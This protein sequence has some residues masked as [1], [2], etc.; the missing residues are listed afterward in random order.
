M[1]PYDLATLT[2]VKSW[3]FGNSQDNNWPTTGDQQAA[4][5][6]T[7]ASRAILSYLGRGTI[8]PHTIT[9][10]RSGVGGS[11]MMLKDY[12]VLYVNTLQIGTQSIPKRPP[13]S[14]SGSTQVVS[15]FPGGPIGWALDPVWDGSP[16]GRS[17]IL[18]VEGFEFERGLS[19]IVVNYRAGY[20][21]Y[22]EAAV[23]PGPTNKVEC[24]NP[25]GRWVSDEGVQFAD[26]TALTAVTKDP[27]A[28]QYVPPA[29]NPASPDMPSWSYTFNAADQGKAVLLAYGF[30]PSD[31]EY[32]CT[33]WV[34]EWWAYKARPG[35]RSRAMPMGAGTATFDLSAM[36][37]D[38]KL[39]LQ[40]FKR[41]VS[42]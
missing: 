25:F 13:L 2:G 6:I 4:A 23:I 27:A 39:I 42:L 40:P 11:R 31:L 29:F 8:L 17:T 32:C 1:N 9:E 15:T 7:A 30:C 3:I 19:N 28:G 20:A 34:G 21:V 35:E 14:G 41:M 37:E 36:P 22:N 26:G 38:V 5:F 10:T 18:G 12:P 33:K 16:P 24:Q